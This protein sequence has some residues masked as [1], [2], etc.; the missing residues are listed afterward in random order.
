MNGHELLKLWEDHHGKLSDDWRI[1]FL[2]S[3]EAQTIMTY[4]IQSVIEAV[5]REKMLVKIVSVLHSA[6]ATKPATA[7]TNAK[8]STAGRRS[9]QAPDLTR[10]IASGKGRGF[11]QAEE[12]EKNWRA[13]F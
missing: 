5:S 9:R 8:S 3:S 6:S 10:K 1:R 2:E 12:D 13:R 4:P 7:K 11:R